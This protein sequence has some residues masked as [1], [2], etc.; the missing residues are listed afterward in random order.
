MSG[1]DLVGVAFAHGLV[2]AVMASAVGHI[3]GGHFNPA[4]TFASGDEADGDAPC[5]R[6]LDRTVV[7]AIFAALLLWWIYPSSRIDQVKLGAPVLNG[8]IG[9]GAGVVVEAI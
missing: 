7:G 2:I 6:L 5:R 3:S 9:S 4:V 1:A 8:A